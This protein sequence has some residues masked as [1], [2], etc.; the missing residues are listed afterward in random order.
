[1]KIAVNACRLL[2]AVVFIFSGFVKADDPN[3]TVYKL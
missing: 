1:M 2:L 3:G